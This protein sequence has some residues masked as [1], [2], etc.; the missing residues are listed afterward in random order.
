ML[1]LQGCTS[2]GDSDSFVPDAS[3]T[4][5]IIQC[6]ES[7]CSASQC[8]S[9]QECLFDIS[10]GD[11]T[12]LQGALVEDQ[13][14]FTGLEEWKVP[15]KLGGILQ[16]TPSKGNSQQIDGIIGLAYPVKWM[17]CLPNCAEPPLDA[18]VKEKQIPNIFGN[19]LDDDR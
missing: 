8:Y 15:V 11:Q 10:Y 19:S 1:P 17:T 16:Q 18:I 5:H 6:K 3:S 7:A 9:S 12:H 2:C 13:F 4:S 14:S